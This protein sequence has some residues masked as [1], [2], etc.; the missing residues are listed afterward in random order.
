MGK[1][2]INAMKS[3]Q[4]SRPPRPIQAIIE[5]VAHADVRSAGRDDKFGFREA[6][7]GAAVS[8]PL[9]TTLPMNDLVLRLRDGCVLVLPPS[10]NS[11]TTYAVLEQESWFEKEVAFFAAYLQ[12]GMN[13]LDIGANLGVYAIP[14][15]RLVGPSGQVF[16]YEPGSIARRLLERSR[17]ENAL[18]NLSVSAAAISD[19]ARKARLQFGV[20]SELN[21]LSDDGSG[22]AVQLVTL[23]GEDSAHDWPRID[24]VKMDAEG[25]ELRIL[26][27]AEHFLK[28]HAPLI[29]F[30]MRQGG[31]VSHDLIAAFRARGFGIYRALVGA[32]LL[33]PV[34]AGETI[35]AGELNLFAAVPERARAM[36][37]EG[38]LI[39]AFP[40]YAPPSNTQHIAMESFR[41]HAFSSA[42]ASIREP[43]ADFA[44]ALAAFSQWREQSR[45]WPERYAAL[46]F[47][48]RRL[49][50][51][52]ARAPSLPR[53]SSLMRAGWELGAREIVVASGMQFVEALRRPNT[54]AEP[55]LIATKRFEDTT[56]KGLPMNWFVAA[57]LEQLERNASYSSYFGAT[58]LDLDW[59]AQQEFVAAEIDRRRL[60]I[61]LRAGR[62]M[63]V[64]DRLAKPAPDHINAEIW[65]RRLVPGMS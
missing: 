13:V 27:G 43:D 63:T 18:G 7:S 55:F 52:C 12:P 11:I 20:S 19:S 6:I 29:M 3:P 65:S 45:E 33:A 1:K 59:L 35:D 26:A 44:E 14:M 57:G 40:S 61:A 54:I 50:Q 31:S 39:D 34:A 64:P 25:E 46:L 56:P 51:I 49:Q 17:S 2:G 21:R 37:A 23:D 38:F 28:R 60:L 8:L 24:V 5:S 48:A 10:L 36:A 9:R 53:L 4:Q 16:A 32:Q 47:A 42:F 15:A 62:R 22:E 58:G 41:A 30:E